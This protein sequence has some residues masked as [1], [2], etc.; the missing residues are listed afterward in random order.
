[1]PARR[2]T[3]ARNETVKCEYCGEYYAVT[4][5]HCPFCD[6]RPASRRRAE[7]EE[8]E[9]EPVPRRARRREAEEEDEYEAMLSRRRP[10][11]PAEDEAPP[12][13]ARRRDGEDGFEE[14][15]RRTRRYEAEDEEDDDEDYD[16]YEDRPRRS[17]RQGG[18]RLVSNTRGGG[19]GSRRGPTA[20]QVVGA[21]LSVAIIA[22]AAYVVFLIA[23]SLLD[24][25]KT[26]ANP[27]G[28]APVVTTPAVSPAPSGT[29]PLPSA[30][31]PGGA[32]EPSVTPGVSEPP[33]VQTTVPAGQTA[34][35]FSLQNAWG[36]EVQD[37]TLDAANPSTTLKIVFT[38]AGTTGSVTW[39]SS[40]AGIVSVDQSGNV[41]ALS[42]GVATV[43]AAMA[44]GY[45]R[46]CIVRSGVG[47]DAPAASPSAS[48]SPSGSDKPAVPPS[49]SASASPSPSPSVSPAPGGSLSLNVGRAENGVDYDF[50]LKGAGDA[51]TLKVKNASGA[52]TWTVND[53]S[54]ATVDA[55]GKVTGVAKGVT[56]VTATVD[57]Q[58]LTCIVRV[59]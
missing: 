11:A 10:K 56:K 47:G 50:S 17:A 45:T 4:Y 21:V 12:R 20:G 27:D 58:T 57:G 53:S 5:K 51:W 3:G 44:G 29:A 34:T 16:D 26:P 2:P 48:P 52:V 36:H 15:P 6:E 55:N 19:Y 41:T 9:Y 31:A 18:K 14:A 8:E 1:M 37:I 42:K 25:P 54:I 38:P 43:T 35:G 49:T 13:R 7:E 33:P 39:S 40:N 59:N 46:T 23:S 28:S 32:A 30:T 24:E 22:A